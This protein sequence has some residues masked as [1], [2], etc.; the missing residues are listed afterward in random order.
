M[1]T[2]RA[3]PHAAHGGSEG[4][5]LV[6]GLEGG[7]DVGIGDLV[8]FAEIVELLHVTIAGE[9]FEDGA[10]GDRRFLRRQ[11]TKSSRIQLNGFYGL[12]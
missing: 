3:G 11:G 1:R 6:D 8:G 10:V 5:D 12:G 4:L 2:S 7:G 9:F